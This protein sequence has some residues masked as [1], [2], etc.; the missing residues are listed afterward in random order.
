MT[1]SLKDSLLI[2]TALLTILGCGFGLGRLSP[3]SSSAPAPTVPAETISEE[4]LTSLRES[5]DLTPEQEKQIAPQLDVLG[6]E[7]LDSRQAALLRYYQ[8]LLKFHDDI[9]PKLNPRQQTLLEA[10]RKLLEKEYLNR[11]PPQS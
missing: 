4:I 1:H 10:N 2:G 8:G 9:F 11:F 7:I 3:S 6:A 5:L